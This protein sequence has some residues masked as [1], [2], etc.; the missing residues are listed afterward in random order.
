MTLTVSLLVIF[1][2]FCLLMGGILA[3]CLRERR[4]IKPTAGHVTVDD[5]IGVS[6]DSDASAALQRPS[7]VSLHSPPPN[8]ADQDD[9]LRVAMTLFGSIFLGAL[10]A[11]ITGYLVFFR[12]W[13]T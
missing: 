8:Q 3:F 10:L 6:G 11:I 4:H 5:S 1:L 2:L 13:N 7:R 12:E 9:D